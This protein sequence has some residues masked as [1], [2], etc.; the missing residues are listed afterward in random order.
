MYSYLQFATLCRKASPAGLSLVEA[1]FGSYAH[2]ICCSKRWLPT[3]AEEYPDF[4]RLDRPWG[5]TRVDFAD[6]RRL[7][8]LATP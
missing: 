5:V 7:A 8:W 3:T 4:S 2:S 6:Y 1:L